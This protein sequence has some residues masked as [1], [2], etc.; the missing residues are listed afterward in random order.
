MLIYIVIAVARSLGASIEPVRH[1]K[2]CA[3]KQHSCLY[4][5]YE[6]TS[7]TQEKYI[8]KHLLITVLFFFRFVPRN[9]VTTI[10]RIVF[11]HV[12]LSALFALFYNNLTTTFWAR[13]SYCFNNRF[14]IFTFRI[15]EDKQ[16]IFRI[17]QTL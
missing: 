3:S 14:C 17:F 1:L 15:S 11:A 4:R 5:F 8:Y 2:A 16:G 12:K 13:F 6:T 7:K 9:V 10:V